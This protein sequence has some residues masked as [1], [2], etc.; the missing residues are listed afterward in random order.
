MAFTYC[1]GTQVGRNQ[2]EFVSLND[3]LD[4]AYRHHVNRTA[5]PH[6]IEA[7]GAYMGIKALE[8]MFE[9]MAK[10][11]V[12]TN[13]C[14]YDELVYALKMLPPNPTNWY[15]NYYRV[16]ITED[17][18]SVLE[19]GHKPKRI[20]KYL[21]FTNEPIPGSNGWKQWVLRKAVVRSPRFKLPEGVS[22]ASN[23]WSEYRDSSKWP[24]VY[25]DFKVKNPY[26]TPD[27]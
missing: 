14:T 4:E 16:H 15:F 12:V 18:V 23:T 11:E 24:M 10:R 22:M 27:A 6:Y 20:R 8:D 25:G 7:A 26:Y 13:E 1:Y 21:E 2:M 17:F 19:T 5:Q 9:Y 3:A